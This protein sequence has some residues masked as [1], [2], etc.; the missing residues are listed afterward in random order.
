MDILRRETDYAIRALMELGREKKCLSTRQ[1]AVRCEVTIDFM[2]K[3][4]PRLTQAGI[5][6][7]VRGSRG[8]FCLQRAPREILLQDI[9]QT[10]QGAVQVNRCVL[11]PRRCLRSNRCRFR[12]VVMLI[13]RDIEKTLHA[14]SLADILQPE[15]LTAEESTP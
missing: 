9:I 14:T 10:M 5:V 4:M 13:Q 1:L 15:R 3:I 12:P 11:S 6:K 2:R 8:G 7:P